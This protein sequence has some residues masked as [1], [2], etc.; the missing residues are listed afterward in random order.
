[1]HF[2]S[3]LGRGGK[4]QRTIIETK[5]YS[6]HSCCSEGERRR[7]TKGLNNQPSIQPFLH[8]AGNNKKKSAT[9]KTVTSV[10]VKTDFKTKLTRQQQ[11]FLTLLKTLYFHYDE[12]TKFPESNEKITWLFSHQQATLQRQK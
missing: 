7:V 6:M 5:Y 9:I 2:F 1:M 10:N 11:E 12:V 8:G 3:F 4:S